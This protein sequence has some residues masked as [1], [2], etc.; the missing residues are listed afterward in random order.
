MKL[1]DSVGSNFRVKWLGNDGG[2]EEYKLLG[3]DEGMRALYMATTDTEVQ[4]E[5]WTPFSTVDS[6]VRI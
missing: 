3:I 5:F 1:S 4:D 2:S 6:M